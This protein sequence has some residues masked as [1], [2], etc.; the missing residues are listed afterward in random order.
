MIELD[1]LILTDAQ[2]DDEDGYVMADCDI[3]TRTFLT[4]DNFGVYIDYDGLE[5]TSFYSGGMEH[6]SMMRYNEF[7][8][9]MEKIMKKKKE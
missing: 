8:A 9:M 2:L 5:Y 1:V 6:I 3:S 7:K 4:I